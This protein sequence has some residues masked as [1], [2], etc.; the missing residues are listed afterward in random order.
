MTERQQHILY[1][2]GVGLPTVITVLLALMLWGWVRERQL[3]PPTGP[4]PVGRAGFDWTDFGGP[5]AIVWFPA[6]KPQKDSAA[7]YVPG[8]FADQ[9]LKG[10]GPFSQR[11]AF[12]RDRAYTGGTLRSL[13]PPLPLVVWS[14][15]WGRQPTAYAVL[16]EELASRGYVVA[17]WS[18]AD[19]T[20]PKQRPAQVA[21]RVA[22][23]RA[24]L[25]RIERL[26]DSE[27]GLWQ[28]LNVKSVALV[29]HGLGGEAS[30]RVCASDARCA[31]A[32]ALD[33]DFDPAGLVDGKPTLFVNGGGAPLPANAA[34]FPRAVGV[35]VPRLPAGHFTDDAVFFQ[36]FAWIKHLWQVQGWRGLRIVGAYTRTFLDE[37]LRGAGVRWLPSPRG[38]Y[39]AK[40]EF[41]RD[42]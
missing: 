36:P 15:D 22:E 31:A 11:I 33:A 40:L 3:P 17:G 18:P 9:M 14:P 38:P 2:T 29:G 24:F 7:D 26:H 32:V 6:E 4:Y 34:A 1:W 28:R 41:D 13:R 42:R 10:R 12:V 39:E 8:I 35:R 30:V 27:V 19:S 37:H 23:L 20:G 5:A 25:D 16:A 21:A